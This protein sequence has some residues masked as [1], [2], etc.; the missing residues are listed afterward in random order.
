MRRPADCLCL[1]DPLQSLVEERRDVPA[2]D[3]CLHSQLRC[4]ERQRFD[5][6]AHAQMR[7]Y[8]RVLID[9]SQVVVSRRRD[10][11]KSKPFFLC[12]IKPPLVFIDDLDWARHAFIYPSFSV[13][14]WYKWN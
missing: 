8:S 12:F 4:L 5:R 3:D 2:P 13:D 6:G 7:G 9:F 1:L 10:L 11:I 14:K